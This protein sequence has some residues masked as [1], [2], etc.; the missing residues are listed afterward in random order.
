MLWELVME[1]LD[2]LRELTPAHARKRLLALAREQGPAA[3]EAL[4]A[5]LED[6]ELAQAALEALGKVPDQ[7]AWQLLEQAA[8]SGPARLRKTARRSQHRLRSRG[9]R[10]APQETTRQEAAPIVEQARATPFDMAGNQFLRLIRPAPLGMVRYA[11]FIVGPEGLI[12]CSYFLTNRADM[13]EA[14]AKENADL[15]EEMIDVNLAYIARRARAAAAHNRAVGKA[16][17]RDWSEAARL[18]EDAPEDPLPAKLAA[19]AAQEGAVPSR[20]A[21]RLFDH[22]SMV[23]WF[24]DPNRLT[25]YAQDWL[26][27]LEYQPLRTEEG[28]PNLGA[29]QAQGQLTARIVADLCDAATIQRLVGQLFEQACLFYILGD[30]DR[31]AIAMR[32][33]VGLEQNPSAEN[34][35]LRAMVEVSMGLAVSVIRERAAEESEG[36][37]VRGGDAAGPLWVPR[38]AALEADEEEEEP[39]RL[40]LP[41]QQ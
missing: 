37:W 36:P 18:L 26:H 28:L 22:P 10:P 24:F 19:S 15:G 17:P 8:Q 2:Q 9:F 3:L 7:G 25:S 1:E 35:F 12:D 11:N 23:R 21:R 39:P 38:P 34:A 5:A 32:C 14:L 30:H 4:R 41:G 31:A 29:I 27:L 6:P 40:W 33:S 20:D 16:I 13:E